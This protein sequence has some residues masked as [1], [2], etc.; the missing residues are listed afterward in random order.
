M[1]KEGTSKNENKEENEMKFQNLI[2]L[3]GKRLLQ[4]NYK[5]KKESKPLDEENKRIV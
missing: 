3:K 2:S 5:Q 4:L 1:C